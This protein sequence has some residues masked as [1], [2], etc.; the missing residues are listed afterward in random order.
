MEELKQERNRFK[1]LESKNPP[2]QHLTVN[3]SHLSLF[4]DNSKKVS[5]RNTSE[6]KEMMQEFDELNLENED[7]VLMMD[8]N[9][10]S[11][12]GIL[13]NSG[14]PTAD[15]SLLKLVDENSFGMP[16]KKMFAGIGGDCFESGV[17]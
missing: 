8:E 4:K 3:L 5:K 15:K 9:E 2:I 14:P 17:T 12:V 13:R 1:E 7:N 11:N 10:L 16:A 6:G